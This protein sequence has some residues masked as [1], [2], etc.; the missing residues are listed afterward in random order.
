MIDF[1][2]Q[3]ISVVGG[4]SILIA[5]A[6]W[7][8]SK[9]FENRMN[10][11]FETYKAHLKAESDFEV[12]NL[13]SKL[14]M[15]TKEREIAVTWIYQKRAVAIENLYTSLVELQHSVRIVLDIFSPRDPNEIRKYTTEAFNKSQEVYKIYLKVKIFMTPE[16]CELV[17]RVLNGIQD[18]I[19]LYKGFLGNYEDHELNT[20]V[21][22]KEYAWKDVQEVFRPALRELEAEFRQILGGHNS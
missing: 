5:A 22:V 10:R 13:K 14:Q 2:Y 6:G 20:L 12:E 19:A 11:D 3:I 8:A 4:A 21:D 1:L 17:E 9:I 18:P 15:A 7:I 16:T